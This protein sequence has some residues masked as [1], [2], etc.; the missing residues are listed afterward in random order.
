[1]ALS[2]RG[3]TS[4]LESLAAACETPVTLDVRAVELPEQVELAAYFIVSEAL[5]N[6]D[7]HAA[8]SAVRIRVAR[9]DEV[10]R[11]EI[12]DDG[13]GGA[14]AAGGTGLHGLA[15]R[16]DALG[17]RFEIDSPPGV[18]TRVSAR[19]PLPARD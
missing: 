11:L 12:A 5:T 15:E 4:A 2:D 3:L 9:D 17:G 6:A 7:K 18:G 10:L 1:V 16:V 13:R 19:L 14:D 8:A